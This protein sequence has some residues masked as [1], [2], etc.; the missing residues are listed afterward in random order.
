MVLVQAMF[1]RSGHG[2]LLSWKNTV[3]QESIPGKVVRRLETL[4]ETLMAAVAMSPLVSSS[5]QDAIRYSSGQPISSLAE[6]VEGLYGMPWKSSIDLQYTHDSLFY[7]PF[8]EWQIG[9]LQENLT[10]LRL[11]PTVDRTKRQNDLTYVENSKK[12][13]RMITLCFES[14][15]YRLIR[16]TYLDAGVA[17]QVFTSLFYPRV[18]IPVLGIDF[19]QFNNQ[20]RH[21]TVVDMQPIHPSED[22]HDT[23]YTHLLEPIRNRYPSLQNRMSKAFYDENQFITNATGERGRRA[24][25]YLEG[26]VSRVH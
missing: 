25:L 1:V 18:N 23:K 3:R 15:E 2:W 22:G 6:D 12:N 11:I 24:W 8:W 21:L 4:T 13:K 17:V 7:M 5:P 14:D 20:T 9:F 26:A 16:M 19:L 10:N